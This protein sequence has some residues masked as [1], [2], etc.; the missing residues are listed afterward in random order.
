LTPIAVLV[1]VAAP[2]F[3]VLRF[4]PERPAPERTELRVTVDETEAAGKVTLQPLG[5][6]ADRA[7]VVDVPAE[8]I[9]IRVS[10]DAP[11]I[12]T[13]EVPGA[14]QC[15]STQQ[16]RTIEVS[17]TAKSDPIRLSDSG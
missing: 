13:A 15:T 9:S 12:V 3:L 1:L 8:G 16:R 5:E 6:E 10:F 14:E 2:L 7:V 17:C 4:V 11:V